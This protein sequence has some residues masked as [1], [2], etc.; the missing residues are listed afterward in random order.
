MERVRGNDD[1]WSAADQVGWWGCGV[2]VA[3]ITLAAL[4]VVERVPDTWIVLVG[5]AVIPI[6]FMFLP[7]F[8]RSHRSEPS[9]RSSRTVPH[10]GSSVRVTVGA[11][12]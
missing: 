1:A 11:R 9:P 12:Q 3:T 6:V 2:L 4:D 8:A 5:F 10:R 7:P